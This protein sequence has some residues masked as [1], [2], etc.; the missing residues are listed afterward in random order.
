MGLWMGGG[1]KGKGRVIDGY[2]VRLEAK[3]V[4]DENEFREMTRKIQGGESG[5]VQE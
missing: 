2:G 3:E 5:T 4:E 1:E